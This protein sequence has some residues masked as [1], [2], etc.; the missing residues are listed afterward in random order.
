MAEEADEDEDIRDM[1]VSLVTA[2]DPMAE[3]ES[4]LK[5]WNVTRSTL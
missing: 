4:W 1:A 2:D 3:I 5:F